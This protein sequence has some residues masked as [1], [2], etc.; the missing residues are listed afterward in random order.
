MS[1]EVHSAGDPLTVR[2]VTVSE[3]LLGRVGRLEGPTC[4]PRG[5]RRLTVTRCGLAFTS[6]GRGRP[7]SATPGSAAKL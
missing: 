7:A 5:T 1:I 6:E 2:W 3:A 4:R